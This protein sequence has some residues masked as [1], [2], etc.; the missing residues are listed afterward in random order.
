MLKTLLIPV[1]LEHRFKTRLEDHQRQSTGQSP[2]HGTPDFS[3]TVTSTG[4]LEQLPPQEV[5]DELYVGQL[6]SPPRGLHELTARVCPGQAFISRSNTTLKRQSR[7]RLAIWPRSIG[8]PTC[9]RPCVYSMPH[10]PWQRAAPQ[11]T[12]SWHCLSTIAHGNTSNM[13]R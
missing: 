3:Q 13:M 5:V 1:D 6:S 9:N 2:R 4:R 10:L 11:G 8:P 12:T 7:T